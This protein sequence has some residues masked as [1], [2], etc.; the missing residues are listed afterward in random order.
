MQ[1][2]I[3]KLIKEKL[4]E[5]QVKVITDVFNENATLKASIVDNQTVVDILNKA[6][7]DLKIDVNNRN[8]KIRELN[9]EVAKAGDLKKRE[10]ALERRELIQDMCTLQ[11][12]HANEKVELVKELFKIPFA[13]RLLRENILQSTQIPVRSPEEIYNNRTGGYEMREKDTLHPITNSKDK[14]T[15]E[16]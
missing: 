7:N 4:P 3:L 14:V 15:S 2:E 8:V 9:E 1:D 11:M 16:E 10:Q 5:M 13:N 6:L 12:K